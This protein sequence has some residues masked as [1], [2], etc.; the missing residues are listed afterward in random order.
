MPYIP[1]AARRLIDYQ[2][3]LD[4]F[5]KGL[6]D[7]SNHMLGLEVKDVTVDSGNL[8]YIIT[9]ICLY[10]LGKNPCYA[11]YN[12]VIGALESAKLELYRRQVVPYEEVKK[13]LNGEVEYE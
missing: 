10:W 5:V 9:R 12:A 1:K 2:A 8:N 11:D 3:G 4:D 13:E 6:R 7:T